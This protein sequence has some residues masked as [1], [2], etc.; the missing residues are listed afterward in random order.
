MNR[1]LYIAS[2]PAPLQEEPLKNKFY[3]LSEYF[4]GDILHPIW[5]IKGPNAARRI[6]AIKR[7]CGDF[8][9]NYTFS[10]HLKKPVRFIKEFFF[11]VYKGLEIYFSKNKYDVIIAY[12]PFLTGVVGY[13]LKLSTGKKLIIELPGNPKK[14]YILDDNKVNFIKSFKSKAGKIITKF[15]IK[16]ADHIKLLYP[17]QINGY[18][19]LNR[20]KISVF[21]D[22]VPITVLKPSNHDEKFVLFLGYPWYL[23]GVDIL[24]K[25]FVKIHES[26]PE[27]RLKIVGHCPEKKYFENFSEGC[28][29][30]ELCNAVRHHIAMDLMKKCSLF[31]LPSRTEAMGRVLLE[32]M[33]FKKPIIAS[34]VDGIPYYIKN[35]YNGIL[36]PLENVEKLADCLSSLLNSDKK[37]KKLAENGFNCVHKYYSEA[38]FTLNFKKMIE[39]VL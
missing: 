7:S 32:A 17:Q 30:I 19:N 25:A 26:F 22:F 33:A 28:E 16:H 4:A 35:N 10:F 5:G 12:G 29:A 9:Y 2:G 31:V 1:I 39:K 23:K 15:L 8:R 38:S 14:S 24:I 37:R 18:K 34:S 27:Y 3:Y 20:K 36:F 13:I 21:H 11:Y 6:K